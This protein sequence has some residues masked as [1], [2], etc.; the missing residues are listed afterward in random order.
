MAGWRDGLK[1]VGTSWQYRF[2]FKGVLYTG[3]TRCTALADARSWL[4]AYKSRLSRGEV[5]D[6]DAP[7]ITRAFND[8]LKIKEGFCSQANLD[9]AKRAME[10]HVIPV[11]G[12]MKADQVRSNDVARVVQTYLNAKGPSGRK[13]TAD[14]AN[15]VIAYLR[16]LFNHL[17]E[18]SYLTKVPFR[19]KKQRTQVKPR[20]TLPLDKIEPFL[21]HIDQ[22]AHRHV[23][24]AVRFM[25]WLGLRETEA[26]GVRRE[27][28]R[29]TTRYAHG[30][31]KG[32]EA[33]ERALPED[34]QALIE[35]LPK[36]SAWILPGEDD[37]PHSQQFTRKAIQ[38]AGVAVGVPG[39]TPHRLRATYATLL[40]QT[41]ASIYEVQKLLRHK[42][43]STTLHY[44]Q[45][46]EASLDRATLRLYQQAH[47]TRCPK[48]DSPDDAPDA[49]ADS[50]RPISSGQ[51]VTFSPATW[52]C[53]T[54][55]VRN[56]NNFSTREGGYVNTPVA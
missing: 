50:L 2:L 21:A 31:T 44:V 37:K 6:L 15:V 17:V 42:D 4:A 40:S 53:S 24:V 51:I 1:K 18:N 7:T 27:W 29:G 19:I 38:R 11:I 36:D 30:K 35:G 20:T 52:V 9:R 46:D 45:V 13:R 25:L 5:G 41:G 49:A 8:W 12:A 3:S 34:L 39:L 26:L 33:V 10:L 56:E 32:K 43:I 54:S 55:L 23:G 48:P 22:H 28:L 47:Q 14:G 16:A